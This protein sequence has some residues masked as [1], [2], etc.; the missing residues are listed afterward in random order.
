MME[1]R[2]PAARRALF[3]HIIKSAYYPY[4]GLPG[5]F[6]T[7]RI[8]AD[9]PSARECWYRYAADARGREFIKNTS[10]N[11]SDKKVSP[12][13]AVAVQADSVPILEMN[14]TLAG[15]GIGLS[16]LLLMLR[17]NAVQ[18][19]AHMLTHYPKRVFRLR[20]PE[21]WLFTAC[22]CAGELSAVAAVAEI[23]RQFPG[24]VASARAPWGNTLLWNTLAN[25]NETEK[26][27]TELIRL[28]CD[29][30]SENEWGLSYQLVTDNPVEKYK[31]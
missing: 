2:I 7:R 19:F 28:G 16:L 14:R 9:N 23:E 31:S 27:Q 29:P 15:C 30:N 22:R 25:D 5:W 24:I 10:G 18:C 12:S 11:F 21:E 17:K 4:S 13:L 1:P 6:Y 8:F 3:W 20:S 26:L